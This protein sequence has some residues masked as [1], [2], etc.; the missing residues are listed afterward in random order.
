MA[1]QVSEIDKAIGSHGLWKRCIRRSIESGKSDIPVET[2]ALTDACDFGK[3][4]SGPTLSA[5]DKASAHYTKV[6]ELHAR[7]HKA[8]AAV[9]GLALS[10]EKTAAEKMVAGNGKF[11]VISAELT[12]A[13][14]EWRKSLYCAEKI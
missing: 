5:P 6:N 2:A 12:T 10:G 9:I 1:L 3:W 11:A 14:L 7:F 13:M 4:L 8:A